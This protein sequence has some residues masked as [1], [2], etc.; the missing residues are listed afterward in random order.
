MKEFGW[1]DQVRQLPDSNAPPFVRDPAQPPIRTTS[2]PP[3]FGDE[4]EYLCVEHDDLQAIFGANR[5]RRDANDMWLRETSRSASGKLCL[6]SSRTKT[7]RDKP[8]SSSH[9]ACRCGGDADTKPYD[10]EVLLCMVPEIEE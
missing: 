3:R 10:A 2:G 7:R 5:D 6:A 8:A 9:R 4:K 1:A